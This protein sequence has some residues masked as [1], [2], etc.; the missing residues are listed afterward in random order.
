MRA[1]IARLGAKLQRFAN[2]IGGVRTRRL[3]LDEGQA[4][5]LPGGQLEYLPELIEFDQVFRRR[6]AAWYRRTGVCRTRT[7]ASPAVSSAVT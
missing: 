5:L 3:L 2:T 1:R 7:A 4:N 6:L